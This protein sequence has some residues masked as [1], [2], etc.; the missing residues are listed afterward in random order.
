[1]RT[2]VLLLYILTLIPHVAMASLHCNGDVAQHVSMVLETKC[3]HS[4]SHTCDYDAAHHN[5]HNCGDYDEV[6]QT[7]SEVEE[8][9]V[10]EVFP[11]QQLFA[12]HSLRAPPFKSYETHSLP[13]L[14]GYLL[15]RT[16]R[17]I[18]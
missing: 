8:Q 15:V 4:S 10:E 16:S 9:S 1:M 13:A 11:L 18:C 6:I 12:D 17:F 7:R 5:H 2:V 3:E 14:Y